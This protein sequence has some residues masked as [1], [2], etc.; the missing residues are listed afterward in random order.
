[1]AKKHH[2]LLVDDDG[3][4]VEV[5]EILLAGRGYSVVGAK[6]A[7][8]AL[9]ILKT[10]QKFDLLVTDVSLPKLNGWQLAELARGFRPDIPVVFVTGLDPAALSE[11]QDLPKGMYIVRKPAPIEE[12]YA[13]L[14]SALAIP[15]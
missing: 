3:D 7:E 9:D 14:D 1:M 11:F 4:L 13:A 15:S 12:F 2:I 8:K 5:Q 10:G 6:S